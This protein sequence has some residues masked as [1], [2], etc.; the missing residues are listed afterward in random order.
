MIKSIKLENFQS[1][2]E[3]KLNFHEGVN[4]IIGASDV[5]KTAILRAL[6]WVKDNQPSGTEFQ[7]HWGGT[8]R[9]SVELAEGHTVIRTRSSKENTYT[10]IYPDGEKEVF[11]AFG[12]SVPE[13]VSSVLNLSE[14]N[15]QK[16]LDG[17]F[18]LSKSPSEVARFLNK[19]VRL[20]IIDEAQ[21]NIN[22]DIRRINSAKKDVE[23]NL[24]ALDS[25]LAD[26]QWITEADGRVTALEQAWEQMTSLVSK[27][28]KIQKCIQRI[29]A[30]RAKRELASDILIYKDRVLELLDKR[31]KR[32]AIQEKQYALSLLI[33]RIIDL[34]R[35]LESK[36]AILPAKEKIFLLLEKIE[37][38]K[39]MIKK[40]NSLADLLD[41]IEAKQKR[42]K[43]MT[44]ELET[45]KRV[46]EESFP[47]ICPLCGRRKCNETRLHTSI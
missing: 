27:S 28:D 36:K 20:D 10:I 38:V 1:H 43:T 33:A 11:K 42:L 32:V 26:L 16:Q 3:T 13:K 25:Q 34:Q 7:S 37:L 35:E 45:R 46:F 40:M 8:T 18:L 19:I 39:S 21:S 17:P 23:L 24:T 9:V 12:Q 44:H 2:K 31:S 47:E 6:I 4:V 29:K 5:G 15:I 41:S 14:V 30:L 22:S